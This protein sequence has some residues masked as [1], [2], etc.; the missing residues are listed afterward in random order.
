MVCLGCEFF[1]SQDSRVR[2]S[3]PPAPKCGDCSRCSRTFKNQSLVMGEMPSEGLHRGLVGCLLVPSKVGC[4]KRARLSLP[5]VELP[6]SH[7][8]FLFA[9]LLTWHYSLYQAS[10]RR[11]TGACKVGKGLSSSTAPEVTGSCMVRLDSS[12]QDQDF[13]A[14]KHLGVALCS[15][16]TENLS[17]LLHPLLLHQYLP[18][19]IYAQDLSGWWYPFQTVPVLTSG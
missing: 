7:V 19:H 15:Q 1:L 4:Y 5:A 17:P 12:Q 2:S 14:L 6:V 11:H 3:L 16:R 10:Q 13:P 8:I 9:S 18:K